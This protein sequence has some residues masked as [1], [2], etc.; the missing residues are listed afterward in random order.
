MTADLHPQV[1]LMAKR[2][3]CTHQHYPS[4]NLLYKEVLFDGTNE[5]RKDRNAQTVSR[6]EW[7]KEYIQ[8]IAIG[9]PLTIGKQIQNSREIASIHP[10]RVRATQHSRDTNRGTQL[11]T[12]ASP[13]SART[14]TG[15]AILAILHM[16]RVWAVCSPNMPS[17]GVNDIAEARVLEHDTRIV[18]PW[19]AEIVRSSGHGLA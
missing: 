2:N 17:S 14:R 16:I 1:N 13:S 9:P 4:L 3:T 7:N 10:A 19:T 6:V 8:R 11:L 5:C 18:A 12:E 15:V